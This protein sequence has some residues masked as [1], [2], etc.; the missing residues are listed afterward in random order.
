[1]DENDMNRNREWSQRG[2]TRR[3]AFGLLAGGIGAMA[4]T[5]SGLARKKPRTRKPPSRVGAES[6][7]GG[8]VRRIGEFVGVQGTTFDFVSPVPD[9][10]GWATP[11][12]DPPLFAW[13]DYAGVADGFQGLKLGTKFSGTVLLKPLDDG[14]AEVRVILNTRNALAWVIELDLNGD[15]LD[16]IANKT[17]LFGYRPQEAAAPPKPKPSLVDSQFHIR[18]I[19]TDLDAPLPDLV[20]AAFALEPDPPEGFELISLDFRA[21]GIGTIRDGNRRGRLEIRQVGEEL[22]TPDANFPAE[23]IEVRRLGR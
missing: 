6:R 9:V 18:F 4:G 16:Q 12:A 13:V 2:L 8:R 11:S 17:P 15:V 20:E 1:M 21:H 14:R 5:E 7:G 10:V 22:N 3:V 19:N 23:V